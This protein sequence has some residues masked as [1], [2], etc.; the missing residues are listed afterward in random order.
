MPLDLTARM[1][2][3]A[4]IAADRRCTRTDLAAAYVLVGT[5]YNS[6]TGRCDA[7]VRARWRWS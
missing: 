6:A 7:S 4:R 1:N 5:Y 3:I 2:L